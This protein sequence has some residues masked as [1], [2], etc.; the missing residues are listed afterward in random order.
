MFLL[1]FDEIFLSTDP[2]ATALRELMED[3]K[4]FKIVD[5][6]PW[7]SYNHFISA[8]A[9]RQVCE[10]RDLEYDN[11]LAAQPQS[12][13]ELLF[14]LGLVNSRGQPAHTNVLGNRITYYS[15]LDYRLGL[16]RHFS[17]PAKYPKPTPLD[18]ERLTD[19]KVQPPKMLRVPRPLSE[20][21]IEAAKIRREYRTQQEREKKAAKSRQ[22]TAAGG[23]GLLAAPVGAYLLTKSVAGWSCVRLQSTRKSARFGKNV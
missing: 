21:K 15:M 22:D 10:Y 18:K 6:A 1:R 19:D 3:P 7:R 14:A 5:A 16:F 12:S 13:L 4:L 23:H 20:I 9:M 11:F 2:A 17:D 8:W